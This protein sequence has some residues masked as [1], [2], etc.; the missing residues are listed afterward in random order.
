MDMLL[1]GVNGC[2]VCRVLKAKED[3]RAIPVLMISAHP[4]AQKECLAAG[5]DAFM[6][7]PIETAE[8][9]AAVGRLVAR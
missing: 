3:L 6:A 5:A 2:D 7:K 1:S 8:F 4:G 9:N